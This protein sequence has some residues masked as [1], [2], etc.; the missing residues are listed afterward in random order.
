MREK[1][2]RKLKKN[3]DTAKKTNSSIRRCVVVRMTKK[4]SA[5][6]EYSTFNLR[7]LSKILWQPNILWKKRSKE[8]LAEVI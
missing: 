4:K 3:V 5:K 8:L 6:A 1:K 2:F 7:R